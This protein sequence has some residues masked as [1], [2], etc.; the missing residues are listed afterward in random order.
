MWTNWRS[1][2]RLDSPVQVYVLRGLL[3]SHNEEDRLRPH[4]WMPV[5]STTSHTY[6]RPVYSVW[7][8]CTEAGAAMTRKTVRMWEKEVHVGQG[9]KWVEE[10][11]SCSWRSLT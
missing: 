6:T 4:L 5:Y 9:G 2:G 11:G 8:I 10:P 1:V 7:L 3:P